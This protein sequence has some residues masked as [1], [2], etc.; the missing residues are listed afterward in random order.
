MTDS[1]VMPVRV[2]RV[3][4]DEAGRHGNALGVID[5]VRVGPED[6]Q[7]VAHKLGFSETIFI[8]DDA[9]GELRIFTPA[10]ELPLAGHPLVGAAWF[11]RTGRANSGQSPAPLADPATVFELRPPGGVVRA[12]ADT[13][14]R[15]WI[16]APLATLPDWTLFELG[17][18]AAV[19][20]LSGPL[21]PDHDHVVYWAWIQPGMLRVRCFAP[22]FGVPEDEAT[23]SAALRLAA[24]L[25]H[26][27]EIRQ[28]RGSVLAA[29]PVDAERGAV[30]GFVAEDDPLPMP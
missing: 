18:P 22:L 30:G 8:D 24:S 9:T 3:F 27:I 2:L 4:T 6:R 7:R 26:P 20:E 17:S 11:L 16:D 23:G 29:R 12:W 14:G 28:G 13:D 1:D 19:E 25:G 21:Q 5:G 15:T 10:T